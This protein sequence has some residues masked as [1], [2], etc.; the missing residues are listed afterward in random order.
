MKTLLSKLADVRKNME[1]TK[2]T[3]EIND[4]TE[5]PTKPKEC[6]KTK[7]LSNSSFLRREFKI[8]GQ[9]DEPG[10]ADKLTFVKLTLK[11]SVRVVTKKNRNC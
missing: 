9:I 1:T 10:Q 4:L 7:D 8:S 5:T 3:N 11:Q 6:M 2:Q